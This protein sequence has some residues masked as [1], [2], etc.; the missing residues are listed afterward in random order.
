LVDHNKTATTGIVV[1]GYYRVHPADRQLFLDAVIPEMIAAQAMLGCVYYAF[2]QDVIDPNA[3]HLLEGWADRVA[4]ERHERSESF[5]S[6]LS[7]VVR[8][9]RIMHREGMRYVVAK[10]EVDDPRNAV[11]P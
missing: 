9:V 5:L 2:A 6:A 10:Q 1:T 11:A 3:F 8:T 4:Y 7:T